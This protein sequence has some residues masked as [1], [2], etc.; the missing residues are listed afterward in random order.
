V[1]ELATAVTPDVNDA[2]PSLE[3]RV[4]R[5]AVFDRMNRPYLEWQLDAFRSVLG[6][7]V[8]EIGCGVGSILDLVGPRD[9]V[10]GVD[11]EPDVL[12][13]TRQR[14]AHRADVRLA[15][16]DFGDP[17]MEAP[18]REFSPDTIL[19][20]NVLEH[21]RDDLAALQRLERVLEPR[22]HL[23]LLVPAHFALYGSYDR[24][25]GHYRRYSR[26]HLRVLL[27]YTG[28]EVLELR[29]FNFLGALGWWANYKLLRRSI[30][31]DA[32]FGLMNRLLPLVRRIEAIAPLPF[33]LSVT[34]LCRRPG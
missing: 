8:L 17:A 4:A 28:L 6:R 13:Y 1:R 9:A 18:L 19:C 29:Y 22:G 32:Q 16:L 30:H 23:C 11:I 10:L 7:R 2:A 5:Y 27:S 20:I 14:L 12:A 25:D 26:S 24:V 15:C 21:V 31:G 3:S 34:A 33:G